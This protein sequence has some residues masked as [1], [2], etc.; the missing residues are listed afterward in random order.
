MD[1]SRI[2]TTLGSP[3]FLTQVYDGCSLISKLQDLKPI[4]LLS[5]IEPYEALATS[6]INTA[7]KAPKIH[8]LNSGKLPSPRFLKFSV[9]SFLLPGTEYC[10]GSGGSLP[11]LGASSD[12]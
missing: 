1:I 10:S 9:F 5:T 11:N 4:P 6:N 3:G 8:E 7:K 2:P 12:R